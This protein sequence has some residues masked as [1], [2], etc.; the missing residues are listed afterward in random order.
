MHLEDGSGSSTE[1]LVNFCQTTQKNFPWCCISTFIETELRTS[2]ILPECGSLKRKF[3]SGYT[4][5]L[6]LIVAD[7]KAALNVPTLS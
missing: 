3:K 7:Q 1:M 2:N 6:T 5:T 4:Q